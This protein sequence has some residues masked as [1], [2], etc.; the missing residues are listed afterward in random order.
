MIVGPTAVGKTELSIAVAKQ[1]DAEIISADSMQVYRGMD[2]G[3]AKPSEQERQGIPHH[4]IDVV[5]PSH[6]FTVAEYQEL[7]EKAISD[8]QEKGKVPLL[9]GGTGLYIRAVID[10]FDFPGQDEDLALRARLQRF[11]QVHGNEALHRMLQKVDPT[12]AQRLH[13][14]DVRRVIRALEVYELTGIPL[15]QHLKGQEDRPPRHKAVMFGL[16]RPRQQLYKRCDERVELM[17]KNGLL[18]E[19][20]NLL[21][22]GFDQ[23]STALQ[24]IGYKE[25]I[26]YFTGQY[27]WDEAVRLLKRN[28]R[29]YAKRQYTWFLR[30]NRITW[31][32]LSQMSLSDAAAKIVECY[33]RKAASG[34]EEM[35]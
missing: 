10:G 2:I 8:I 15:S 11:A 28:T 19:V 34:T 31:L 12:S 32:D 14:N 26:G 6:D 1:L 30:D 5:D 18:D 7:A 4:L 21:N 17:L 9:T 35:C 27:S 16:T 23:R 3:T 20:R 29:R 25:L 22:M 24:A 33:R 13:P